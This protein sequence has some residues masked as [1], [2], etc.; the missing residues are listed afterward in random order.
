MPKAPWQTLNNC[1]TPPPSPSPP[2]I[3]GSAYADLNPVSQ[4]IVLHACS[5]VVILTC[6]L[7]FMVVKNS[8]TSTNLQF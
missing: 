8:N 3:C 5:M 6:L 2:K 4:F 1:R 7:I